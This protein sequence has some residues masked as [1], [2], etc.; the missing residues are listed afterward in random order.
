MPFTV[1]DLSSTKKKISVNVAAEVVDHAYESAYNQVRRKANI[2]GFRKGKIPDSILDQYYG[3]EIEM[4]CLNHLVRETYEQVLREKNLVPVLDPQFDVGPINRGTPYAYSLTVEVRPTIE[5][6]DYKGLTL[7]KREAK[8][9]ASEVDQQLSQIQQARAELKPT[10]EGAA[11]AKGMVATIDFEGTIDGKVFDGGTAK[12]YQLEYGNG[13]FLK[14]FEAQIEGMKA[15]ETRVIDVTFPSDYFEAS[16]QNKPAKFTV[17]LQA[18]HTKDL[19]KID[20][21]FAK[22]MGKDSLDVIRKEIEQGL[23]AQKEKAFRGD[24]AKE[25]IDGLLSSHAIDLPEGLIQ[26]ELKGSNKPREEVEKSLR[27]Q[28]LLDAIARAE[29]LKVEPRELEERF[30]YLAHLYQQP[31]ATLRQYYK[32]QNMVGR[33]MSQILMEKTLDLVIDNA[34]LS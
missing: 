23:L 28:F 19:P 12:G 11:L 20:D 1:E 30:H 9:E 21:E 25:V 5:L 24:Y 10:A 15:G 4:E 33:L 16:L 27:T 22:D 32:D 26:D 18:L 7:K 31:V 29:N 2:K 3:S 17:T 14:D 34:T 13:R 8:V 6:K